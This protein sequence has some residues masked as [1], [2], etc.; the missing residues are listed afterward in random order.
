MTYN[1]TID[2]WS[3][4][5]YNSCVMGKFWLMGKLGEWVVEVGGW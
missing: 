5:V 4:I 2:E 1:F 3:R